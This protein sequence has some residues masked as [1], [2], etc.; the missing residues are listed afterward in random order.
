MLRIVTVLFV[1]L[2]M[3]VAAAPQ[4]F[5]T[6]T[7]LMDEYN[8]YSNDSGTFK[9]ISKA[10]LKIQISPKVFSGDSDKAIEVVSYKASVYAAYRTLL[11]TPAKAVNVTVVPLSFDL[12]KQKKFYLE[13]KQYSFSITKEKALKLAHS[14]AG[15][16]NPDEIIGS[17]GYEWTD[18]FSSCC[19]L[20][21]GHP[22]VVKFARQFIK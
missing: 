17:D 13:D 22:G 11:Q 18:N 3:I 15:T 9:V 5:K 14:F 1:S 20:E 2:P 8:D 4:Q 12:S 19:Y 16:A 7:A 21:S 6:V 10:P